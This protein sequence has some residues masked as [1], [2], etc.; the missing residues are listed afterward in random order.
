M[1]TISD[2][3][4]NVTRCAR[5][6]QRRSCRV[7]YVPMNQII[8]YQ[9]KKKRSCIALFH[10]G[11]RFPSNYQMC[12]NISIFGQGSF[13]F[14]VSFALAFSYNTTLF[15]LCYEWRY[16]QSRLIYCIPV[17]ERGKYIQIQTKDH[18]SCIA[19]LR[20]SF[21]LHDLGQ[22]SMNDFDPC[23]MYISMY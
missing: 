18:W 20:S 16:F 19:Y 13:R 22:R 15:M 1:H 12:H 7:N 6:Q 4:C 10:F 3:H 14:Y 23:Y 2:Y 5:Q 21:I 17:T 9:K 8:L 11:T